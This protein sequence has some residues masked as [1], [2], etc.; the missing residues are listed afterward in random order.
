MTRNEF[1]AVRSY[2]AESAS[3]GAAKKARFDM[4]CYGAAA[5][6]IAVCGI[7]EPSWLSV[8]MASAWGVVAYLCHR[9]ERSSLALAK[10]LYEYRAVLGP[11]LVEN[12]EHLTRAL[13]A[14]DGV[15]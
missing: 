6:F 1:E 14:K 9:M 12:D 8:V 2:F 13:R 11:A 10:A 4:F 15:E 5:L 3:R 7:F